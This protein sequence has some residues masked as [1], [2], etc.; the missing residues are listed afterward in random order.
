MLLK[1]AAFAANVRELC[2]P[3]RWRRAFDRLLVGPQR[4]PLRLQQLGQRRLLDA[5]PLARQRLHQVRQRRGGPAHQAQR[6][7]RGLHCLL[8]IRQQRRVSHRQRFPAA[9][10]P[11]DACAG[12][13]VLAC[14]PFL[15]P[16]LD[17]VDRDAGLAGDHAGA[18]A[19]LRL[20][21]QVLT[22]LLLI[23]Q[24]PQLLVFFGGGERFHA[25]QPR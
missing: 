7:A 2:I 8:Q 14:R 12:L 13:V 5:M 23:Q 4:K 15:Q 24:G 19:S 20:G 6:I 21:G 10:T 22:P 3:I 9:A 1:R 17:R 11:A 25:L 18:A 16:P